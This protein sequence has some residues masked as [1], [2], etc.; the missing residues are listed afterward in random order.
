MGTL[1]AQEIKELKNLPQIN[2]DLISFG[3]ISKI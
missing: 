1:T 2:T 3:K